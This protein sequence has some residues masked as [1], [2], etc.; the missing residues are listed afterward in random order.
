MTWDDLRHHILSPSISLGQSTAQFCHSRPRAWVPHT[1]RD[2]IHSHT[3][4]RLTR[5]SDSSDSSTTVL[6]GFA[7]LRYSM[8]LR[9]PPAR[10]LWGR[11]TLLWSLCN[12]VC[13]VQRDTLFALLV[14]DLHLRPHSQDN[15]MPHWTQLHPLSSVTLVTCRNKKHRLTLQVINY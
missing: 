11:S 4:T 7:M 1:V 14:G 12:P 5:L 15:Q 10:C 6:P 13:E 8:F 2:Y 3:V 9:L